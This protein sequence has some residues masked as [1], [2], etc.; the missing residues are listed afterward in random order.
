[1]CQLADTSSEIPLTAL[2]ALVAES[3]DV[4]V[5]SARSGDSVAVTEIAFVEDLAGGPDA[6]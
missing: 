2:N 3:I 5:H 1:M 4:V 6:T